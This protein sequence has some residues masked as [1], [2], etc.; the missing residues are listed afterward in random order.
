MRQVL[1]AIEDAEID[2]DWENQ[3]IPL[4]SLPKDN[5]FEEVEAAAVS[6]G[7]GG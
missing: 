2:D 3:H 7:K 4:P 5:E 1:A 6:G